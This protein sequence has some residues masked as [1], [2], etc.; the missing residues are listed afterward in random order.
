MR[1][2]TPTFIKDLL[3]LNRFLVNCNYNCDGFINRM[4]MYKA[5]VYTIRLKFIK[6]FL[7]Q[8]LLG[9]LYKYT[10]FKRP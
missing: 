7:L 9:N 2:Q 5:K 1:E 3:E 4:I 8:K 10:Y 6:I